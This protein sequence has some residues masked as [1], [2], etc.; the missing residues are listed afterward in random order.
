MIASTKFS[1][2]LINTLGVVKLLTL[3]FI[4]ITGFVVLGGHTH[5][6]DPHANFR[7]AFAGTKSDGYTLSNALVS[8]IFSYGGYNNSFN[9]VNEV[10]D[11]IRTIKRT[12]NSAVI[13]VAILY[14]LVNIAYFAAIPKAEIVTSTQVTATLFFTKLFGERAAK[15]LTIL[16]ILSAGGNIL[17]VIVGHARMIREVGRQG[18][19]PFPKFFVST[20]PFGTPLGPVVIIWLISV[21]MIVIPPA[22]DAFNFSK[23]TP[24]SELT[25]QLSRC[26]TT[27]IRRSSR[28]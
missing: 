1:L 10:K 24:S 7:N 26:R 20:R 13:I 17:A 19:L 2:K 16:P 15:G 5:V 21:L 8:I 4:T 28:S 25:W 9:V 3:L 22:G 11:P 18:V 27:L 23:L 12:A 6:K 14:I